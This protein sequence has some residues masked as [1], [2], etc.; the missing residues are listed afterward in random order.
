MGQVDITNMDFSCT[1][2]PEDQVD[3][4][5]SL[6]LKDLKILLF[7][8]KLIAEGL[9]E[10]EEE[11]IKQVVWDTQEAENLIKTVYNI[12]CEEEWLHLIWEYQR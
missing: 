3:P 7:F 12:S 9:Y 1:K 6:L 4:E 10:G 8:K 11:E 2:I 5:E